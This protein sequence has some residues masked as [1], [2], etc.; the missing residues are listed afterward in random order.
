MSGAEAESGIPDLAWF[1]SSYSAGNGGECVEVASWFGAT[2]VRDTKDKAG[3]MVS[4]TPE[5]WAEFV[6]F[7]ARHP[8]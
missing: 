3:V 4:L 1:K 6:G 8:V 5:A 2:H 7:A